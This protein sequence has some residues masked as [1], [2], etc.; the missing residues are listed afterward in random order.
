MKL[1]LTIFF[2]DVGNWRSSITRRLSEVSHKTFKG[3]VGA[4]N[5]MKMFAANR[6]MSRDDAIIS[7]KLV[8]NTFLLSKS[9]RLKG[10]LVP[11]A[12]PARQTENCNT[13][14]HNSGVES[15]S[16][17]SPATVQTKKTNNNCNNAPQ[18]KSMLHSATQTENHNNSPHS[19]SR[20]TPTVKPEKSNN[21]SG[22]RLA[23]AAQTEK[24]QNNFPKSGSRLSASSST[25][26]SKPSTAQTTNKF[27]PINTSNSV[28]RAT[29]D[30]SITNGKCRTLTAKS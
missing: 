5:T 3:A 11:A 15:G 27:P 6:K 17:L 25:R 9:A 19:G 12:E 20:L 28:L 1:K 4:V 8:E 29:S 7:R 26:T 24:T 23:S 13:S 14:S 21:Q 10:I 18:S 30:E 22:R 2:Q 16:G